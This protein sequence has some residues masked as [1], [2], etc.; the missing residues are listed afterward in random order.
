M[1]ARLLCAMAIALGS[2]AFHEI[3]RADVPEADVFV[4][5]T[6]SDENPGTAERPVA[7]VARAQELVRGKLAGGAKGATVLIRGG[8]YFLREPLRFGPEDSAGD[9]GSVTYAAFPGEEVVLSGGS[10][11]GPW[12]VNDGVWEADIP[13]VRSGEWRFRDLYVAGARQTRAREPNE[14]FVRVDSAG[15]D[16]R[17]SFSYR[18]GDVKPPADLAGVEVVFLHDWSTSRVGVRS[19]DTAARTMTFTNPIGPSSPHFAIDNFESHP[20]YFLE[21]AAEYLDAPGEWYLDTKSGR[22]RYRPTGKIE[23]TDE[24]VIA[25]RLTNLI[26]VSGD[27]QKGTPVRGLRFVGLTFAH[28]RWDLPSGGYAAGQA[29][30]FEPRDG[31]RGG[32]RTVVD[33]AVLFDLAEICAV[34]RCHFAHLGGCGVYFRRSCHGNRVARCVVE[35]VAGNGIMVGETFSRL[36]GGRD[37]L[38]CDGN[39][40]VDNVVRRCGAT[41]YGAVGIWVGITR[42]TLVARNEVS[43][44]PYTGVSLGWSWNTRPTA[45]EGNVVADNRIHRVMQILSDGGGIYTLGRQPDGVLRGN[46]IFDVPPNAG[47]AESNGIFMDEGSSLF[48]VENN[49]IYGIA[50]SPIRFHQAENDTL[51]NNRLVTAPDV[52][53][54]RYNSTSEDRFTF[55]DNSLLEN[56]DWKLPADDPA[57]NAGPAPE[58][59]QR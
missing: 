29:C 5:T 30:F 10:P 57:R 49:T 43:D 52:P 34:E 13:T 15:P 36:D 39:Q 56:A 31:E 6:G 3:S 35:D 1:P 55:R 22:L 11:I 32:S 26:V 54:F 7:S 9:G 17:T 8:T 51:Q 45:S 19:I 16:R 53:H 40:V 42:R 14:G 47:R 23:P 58:A 28:T 24:Q 44:L 33:S 20:R 4:A 59:E 37:D 38:V 27:A 21:N 2:L 41:F 46:L 50:R 12:Q 18:E 25:P 48:V